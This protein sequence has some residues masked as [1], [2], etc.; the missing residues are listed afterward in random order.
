MFQVIIT[1][2][3]HANIP[4]VSSQVVKIQGNIYEELEIGKPI[5]TLKSFGNKA[6]KVD[7][8][9]V[10]PPRPKLLDYSLRS[11]LNKDT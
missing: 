7:P 8:L 11:H 10:D 9:F 4:F 5:P 6:H 2:D 1:P 3:N